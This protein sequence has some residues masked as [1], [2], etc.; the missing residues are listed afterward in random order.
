MS[1]SG[2]SQEPIITGDAASHEQVKCRH[3]VD[4]PVA[5]LLS[6]I[7]FPHLPLPL[8]PD[9]DPLDKGD[10]EIPGAPNPQS[11]QRLYFEVLG[12]GDGEQ[13][14]EIPDKNL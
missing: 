12:L 9:P 5:R 14:K 6:D 10:R 13:K 7:I 8:D 2:C 1:T 11:S 4:F 3:Q